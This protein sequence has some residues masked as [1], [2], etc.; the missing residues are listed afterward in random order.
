MQVKQLTEYIW[1]PLRVGR[2]PH[3][4]STKPL[5]IGRSPCSEVLILSFTTIKLQNRGMVIITVASIGAETERQPGYTVLME[6]T[7]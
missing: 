4:P 3:L 1:P 5:R 6:N 2:P 7:E